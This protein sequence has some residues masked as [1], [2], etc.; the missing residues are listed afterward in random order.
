M[1]N[2]RFSPHGVLL[3]ALMALMV[4]PGPVFADEDDDDSADESMSILPAAPGWLSRLD[5]TGRY[6]GVLGSE[7]KFREDYNIQSGADI[8]AGIH[9]ELDD[10]QILFFEGLGQAVEKQGFARFDYQKLGLLS[11]EAELQAWTEFYNT[12]P[13]VEDVTVLAASAGRI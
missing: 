8:G 7:S 1:M 10:G 2:L 5:A 4:L 13:G 12:R 3:A 11:F 9:E 6:V